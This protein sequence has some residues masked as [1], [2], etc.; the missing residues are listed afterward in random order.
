MPDDIWD[1]CMVMADTVGCKWVTL[2][3]S[4]SWR[5]VRRTCGT[6]NLFLHRSLTPCAS[7]SAL[8]WSFAWCRWILF[9]WRIFISDEILTVFEKTSFTYS[10]ICVSQKSEEKNSIHSHS[11][12]VIGGRNYNCWW[13]R[14]ALQKEVSISEVCFHKEREIEFFWKPL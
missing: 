13:A 3:W 7:S 6:G 12:I 14:T 1:F 4:H 10:V 2:L 11:G 8:S 9:H 5:L